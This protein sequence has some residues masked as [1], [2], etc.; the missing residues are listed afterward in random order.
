MNKKLLMV[1]VGAA[2]AAP[3]MAATAAPTV[4]G[5]FHV[6]LDRADNG[7]SPATET[8]FIANNTSRFGVKGSD[9][10]GGGMKAIYGVEIPFQTDGES[11]SGNTA[12]NIATRATFLGLSGGFGEFKVGKLD[13]FLKSYGRSVDL[14]NERAGDSRNVYA[15]GTGTEGSFLNNAMTYSSPKIAGGLTI[16]VSY[17]TGE[18]D[19]A[20][21]ISTVGVKWASGP[22]MVALAQG[23]RH[24]GT[25]VAGAEVNESIQRLVA[26]YKAGAFGVNFMYDM[27]DN[28]GQTASNRDRTV[29]GLG[30]FFKMGNSTFKIQ[31]YTADGFDNASSTSGGS[32]MALGVDHAMSKTTTAY[33]AYAKSDNDSGATF[34]PAGAGHGDSLTTAAGK[35][36]TVLSVGMEL[37]F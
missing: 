11:G 20:N 25:T 35:S 33:V 14:F 30:A 12:T 37:L 2:L 5:K 27:Q 10:L 21:T 22:L 29:M 34:S 23:D 26:A 16:D 4:Y 6:S 17:S 24:N 13:M 32:V 7:G 36:G 8:G 1:A 3:M 9:D 18:N 19:G 15:G 28:V 31:N